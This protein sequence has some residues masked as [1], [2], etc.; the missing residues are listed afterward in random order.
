MDLARLELGLLVAVMLPRTFPGMNK[1][2]LIGVMF[3][4]LYAAYAIFPAVQGWKTWTLWALTILAGIGR[5]LFRGPRQSVDLGAESDGPLRLR[6]VHTQ[7]SELQSIVVRFARSGNFLLAAGFILLF[8]ASFLF[9]FGSHTIVVVQELVTNDAV[10]VVLSG[11]LAASFVGQEFVVPLIRPFAQ[12]LS[13]ANESLEDIG[14]TSAYIGWIERALVFTFAAGGQPAAAALAITAKT[15]VR[16]PDLGSHPKGFVEYVLIGT[17]GSLLV[18]L[19][20]AIV[21]RL[22]FGLP[23]I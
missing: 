17:L 14:H 3:T 2:Q 12:T 8:L 20:F 11:L 5:T 10:S 4:P 13:A 23:P 15:L 7:L 18:A 9:F 19:T 16:I 21:V 1:N 22:A 6:E